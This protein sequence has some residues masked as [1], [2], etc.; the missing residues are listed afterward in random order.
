MKRHYGQYS[1]QMVYTEAAFKF[2][3]FLIMY[4]DTRILF[5]WFL[6]DDEQ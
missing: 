1:L 3:N 5:L 2:L 4:R 6:I